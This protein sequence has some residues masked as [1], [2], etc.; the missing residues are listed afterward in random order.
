MLWSGQLSQ[1]Y[2]LVMALAL[3][4]LN[5]LALL[6]QYFAH[7]LLY[8]GSESVAATKCNKLESADMQGL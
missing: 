7:V 5:Y 2:S 3:R 6:R 8:R 4:F 1:I